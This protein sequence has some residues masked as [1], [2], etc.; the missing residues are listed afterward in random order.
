MKRQWILTQEGFDELLH[1]LDPDRERAGKRYEEIRLAL[2]RIFVRRG[3]GHA[4]ELADETIN[5]IIK[6]IDVLAPSYS[7]E[8]A[9]YFYAVAQKVFQEYLKKRHREIPSEVFSGLEEPDKGCDCL[10]VCLE[11][12][13]PES[14]WL[15]VEYYQDNKQMKIDNR[16]I[17]AK[18]L[19]TSL[20][21]LRMR[22]H[23]IKGILKDCIE[24]CRSR[25]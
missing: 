14:R 11:E 9:A 19:S 6:K 21:T 25:K 15:I 12:L 13:E 17:L 8:P 1:W 18:Q 7:G 10:P 4:E 20:H 24:D 2:I 5:R 22:V 16:R 23:R 3:C